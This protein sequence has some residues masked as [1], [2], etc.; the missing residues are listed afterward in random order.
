M[1]DALVKS[2]K[3]EEFVS[4][5]ASSSVQDSTSRLQKL[6]AKYEADMA[7]RLD[8]I[9][10]LNDLEKD[11]FRSDFDRFK[12]NFDQHVQDMDNHKLPSLHRRVEELTS[13]NQV[14][15]AHFYQQLNFSPNSTFYQKT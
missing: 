14:N 4:R 12:A 8:S 10:K 5:V 6:V 1:I 9:K 2:S 11:K 13:S 7:S 3:F 15:Q